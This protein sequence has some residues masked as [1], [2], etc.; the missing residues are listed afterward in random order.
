MGKE[1]DLHAAEH[2][3]LIS[4]IP[5]EYLPQQTTIDEINTT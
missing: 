4:E 3:L 1:C 5:L 2:P